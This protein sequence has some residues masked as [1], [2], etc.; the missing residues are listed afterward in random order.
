M[1]SSYKWIASLLCFLIFALVGIRSSPLDEPFI[2]LG[3]LR[4]SPRHH[5]ATPLELWGN[6]LFVAEFSLGTPPQPFRGLI[7]HSSEDLVILSASCKSGS[8]GHQQTY[9]RKQSSTATEIPEK[10]FNP[11]RDLSLKGS[12]AFSD[13]FAI[14]SIELLNQSFWG[15]N[16]MGQEDLDHDQGFDAQLSLSPTVDSVLPGPLGSPF[17]SMIKQ[18]LLDVNCF[19]LKPPHSKTGEPGELT[20]G[21]TS[22]LKRLGNK[23]TRIPLASNALRSNVPWQVEAR[24]V[25][26]AGRSTSLTGHT[27]LIDASSPLITLPQ[28][29]L[30]PLYRALQP[31]DYLG[32][33]ARAVDCDRRDSLPDLT[34]DLGGHNFT[35]TAY[36]YTHESEFSGEIRCLL[37]LDDTFGEEREWSTLGAPFLKRFYS[38]F[39]WDNKNIGLI[40]LDQ[41]NERPRD[42]RADSL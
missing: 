28:R 14:A 38:V 39:D 20:F 11:T 33:T 36:E 6:L 2:D 21:Q 5:G 29:A 17:M 24:A 9:N 27:A 37:T 23:L 25:H 34:I 10:A 4:A 3:F 41:L 32:Y 31:I 40:P 7:Q 15:Y 18:G 30:A 26:T 12:I 16:P 35:I 8:C 19:S 13:T 42:I 22:E 1:R